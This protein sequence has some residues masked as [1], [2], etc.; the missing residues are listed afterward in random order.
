MNEPKDLLRRVWELIRTE[1]GSP[2]SRASILNVLPYSYR[3]MEGSLEELTEDLNLIDQPGGDGEPPPMGV[4]N[5]R[6]ML[7]Y[8]RREHKNLQ[9]EE[10]MHLRSLCWTEL[11]LS[12][13]IERLSIEFGS[14]SEE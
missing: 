1:A 12:T 8:L 7:F 4:V 14:G 10:T 3:D 11:G 13:M 9:Y 2:V 6:D 5:A